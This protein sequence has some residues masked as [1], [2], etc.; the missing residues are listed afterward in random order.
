[1]SCV[2][3]ADWY[4]LIY[5]AKSERNMSD[6]P[7]PFGRQPYHQPY[8]HQQ[9]PR[10]FVSEDTLKT[11]ALQ[12]ERKAFVLALKENPR[13]RFLRIIEEGG[14]KRASIMIPSTGLREFKG[15]LDAMVMA[16]E[17]TP[18]KPQN[19]M[20]PSPPVA[21]APAPVA[22]VQPPVEAKPAKRTMSETA[23]A[24]ISAAAK[25]RWAKIKALGKKTP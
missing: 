15:V 8:G 22:D 25:A 18:A 9:P 16:A 7:S 23:K 2:G 1:M 17:K 10:P 19:A 21:Q 3:R 12:I 14:H 13:G 6:Y 5:E 20:V 24:K 4:F 11:S